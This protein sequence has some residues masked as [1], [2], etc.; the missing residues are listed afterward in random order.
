MSS[1]KTD[2]NPSD[3]GTKQLGCGKFH[4][5]RSM[6]DMDAELSETSSSGK[7]T[8]TND[9]HSQLK[10]LDTNMMDWTSRTIDTC[11]HA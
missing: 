2:V 9:F 11:Q 5:L 3:I 10:S 8:V 7:C 4:R 6:L 1:V